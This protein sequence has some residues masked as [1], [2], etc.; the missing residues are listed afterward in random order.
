M[1]K[2]NTCLDACFGL[3]AD[4]T[5]FNSTE[6][7]DLEDANGFSD[8]QKEYNEH[9]KK[10]LENIIFNSSE[11]SYGKG[12]FCCFQWKKSSQKPFYGICLKKG[13]EPPNP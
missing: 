10:F 2:E 5:Y 12:R 7:L 11:E 6:K 4:V 13:G 9:K 3:Y 1:A 8:L